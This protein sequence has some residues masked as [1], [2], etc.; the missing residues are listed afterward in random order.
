MPDQRMG[1][2][3]EMTSAV[4]R[5]GV[6]VVGAGPTGIGAATR[7]QER[8]ADWLLVEEADRLVVA[9][10]CAGRHPSDGGHY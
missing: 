4:R 6:L 7:L 2:G 5:V 1:A 9:A 3:P 8:S 10:G